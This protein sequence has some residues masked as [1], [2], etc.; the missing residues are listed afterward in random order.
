MIGAIVTGGYG[1]FS[2]R[3]EVITLGYGNYSVVADSSELIAAR[4][5]ISMP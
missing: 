1:S 4:A 3:H 5:A 2:S